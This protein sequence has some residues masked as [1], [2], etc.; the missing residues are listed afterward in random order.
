MSK[1][2]KRCWTWAPYALAVTG[3]VGAALLCVLRVALVPILWD[4]DVGHFAVNLPAMISLSVAL[5]AMAVMAFYTPREHMDIPESRALPTA[6][7]GIL[8]GGALG[9]ITLY[10]AFC[11]MIG[12]VLPPPG[13]MQFSMLTML[14][15]YGMLVFGIL[16]AVA[17][18][19]LGLQVASEGGTRR[20]MRSF[21]VLAPVLWA[22]CRLAWYQMSYTSTVGWS[23]KSYDFLMVI[24]ELLFL[25]K[26]ARMVSGIGKSTI[27]EVL[28]YAMAAA[29]FSLS[30][31]LVRVCLYFIGGA[32]I[33][34][35]GNLAGVA[36]FGIGVFALVF[37][38][39]LVRGYR[40]NPPFKSKPEEVLE[41][42]DDP[43]DSSLESIFILEENEDAEYN[44]P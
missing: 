36:D 11:W 34:S 41:E 42:E 19:L 24:F 7:A 23:E 6:L 9:A 30:G 29:M 5:V 37:A 15:L 8:A 25:F 27:G 13:Q 43:Y 28:F 10:E 20:G 12:G 35:S 44:Q 17:I 2:T 4:S 39:S 33:Y 22:W 3:A 21:S 38:C 1:K 18:V 32:D 40:E 14:L 31:P 16:G 26:V